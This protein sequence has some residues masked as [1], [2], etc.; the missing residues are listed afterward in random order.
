MKT[1]RITIGD[2]DV[3]RLG[4]G[5]M[6]IT[7]KGVWG[8]PP[9]RASAMAVLRRAV[10]L[11][12]DFFDTADSYGPHVSEELIGEALA[13]YKNGIVIATK[14]GFTRQGPD[15]WTPDGHPKHL[16][17]ACEGSLQRLRTERIDLYQLHTPDKN[18]PYAD[19][20][21]ELGRLQQEG[22]VRHI[23]ISNVSIEQLAEAQKLVKVT[24]VQNRYN[25]SDRASEPVLAACEE[26]GLAFLPWYPIAAGKDMNSDA[27]GK[28]AK[29]LD[30]SARQIA[31]AWLLAHSKV[32]L[33][34]PGTSSLEHLAD[35]VAA[36]DIELSADDLNALA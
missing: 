25:L 31:L 3:N 1:P 22:K 4:F 24:S 17:E 13:P 19:S 21:G 18:V 8:P 29:R 14:G 30:K 23:G 34:I 35:N 15:R 5:A 36:A 11:G 16:R 27:L 7:G 26:Q 33:P 9:D 6:R 2:L 20:V 28:V 12:V 32:M 10:E